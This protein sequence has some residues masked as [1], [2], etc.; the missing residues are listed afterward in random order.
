MLMMEDDESEDD[1]IVLSSE[2]EEEILIESK[3]P[4]FSLLHPLIALAVLIFLIITY[5]LLWFIY[6]PLIILI[7][8]FAV[9]TVLFSRQTRELFLRGVSR[10]LPE[11]AVI[12]MKRLFLML[13]VILGLIVTLI[14]SERSMPSL[15]YISAFIL[16]NTALLYVQRKLSLPKEIEV[17]IILFATVV[18]SRQFGFTTGLVMA[19]LG[20]LVPQIV[21]FVWISKFTLGVYFVPLAVAHTICAFISAYISHVPL[22][23]LGLL[24]TVVSTILMVFFFGVV[25]HGPH[26]KYLPNILLDAMFN[27]LV[28]AFHSGS[29]PIRV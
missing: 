17:E 16:L 18:C 28:F 10:F 15:Y 24:C 29:I 25:L 1:E 12:D 14:V 9:L 3:K 5:S 13:S 7:T 21:R 6:I 19:I 27:I 11:G 2:E 23:Q 20:N 22:L 26:P 8:I 4:R